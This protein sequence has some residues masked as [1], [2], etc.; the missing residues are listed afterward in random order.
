MIIYKPLQ[1]KF[2]NRLEAKRYFG[3][4]EFNKLIKN[5]DNFEFINNNAIY[6]ENLRNN[7]TSEEK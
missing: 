6:Y 5:P 1:L 4:T 2:N 7:S 3:H